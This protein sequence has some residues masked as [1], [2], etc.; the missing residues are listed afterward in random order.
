MIFLFIPI[1]LFSTHHIYWI[2]IYG[3]LLLNIPVYIL[4]YIIFIPWDS[5]CGLFIFIPI[6]SL[7]IPALLGILLFILI[8]MY[9]IYMHQALPPPPSPP[10]MGWV[11]YTG[12]IW[13]LPPP[14][15]WCGG[16]VAL[17]PSPPCGV[18]D[19]SHIL[20][21]YEIFPL[22]PLWCGG[23]VALSPSPPCGV[24]DGSHILVPYEI[25]PLPP[26]GV[27]GV[28]HC[29]PPPPVVWWGCGMVWWVCMVCMVGLV[30]HVWKVWYVWYVW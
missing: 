16:G 30:W 23:G 5:E 11:P 22:P 28:W 13:D 8:P 19:G 14:P 2:I 29:P 15:L 9:P 10:H 27:V 18:V 25:F 7:Y 17:S 12:P 24:V 6:Y 3:I 21:P 26:C 4:I 1:D 20:V